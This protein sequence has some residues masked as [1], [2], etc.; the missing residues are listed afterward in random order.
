MNGWG[1]LLPFLVEQGVAR[2]VVVVLV[3]VAL[4]QARGLDFGLGL[5]LTGS[6]PRPEDF[7]A[8]STGWRIWVLVSEAVCFFRECCCCCS[9]LDDDGDDGSA[10]HFTS[11]GA[12]SRNSFL[13]S[14]SCL[15]LFTAVFTRPEGVILGN[16]SL[17]KLNTFSSE[18]TKIPGFG[19]LDISVVVSGFLRSLSL[20]VPEPSGLF[21]CAPLGILFVLAVS[22][23]L[24]LFLR[25]GA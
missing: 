13:L 4:V 1:R 21:L 15:L 5:D 11:D 25:S 12:S 6:E 2:G 23:M 10:A 24:G 20:L 9:C 7:A 16:F 17:N 3:V 18:G 22:S 14:C 19:N 8:A